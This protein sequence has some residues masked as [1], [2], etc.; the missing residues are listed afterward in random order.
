ML[1]IHL[2]LHTKW[3]WILETLSIQQTYFIYAARITT[4][5]TVRIQKYK[6]RYALPKFIWYPWQMKQKVKSKN[7]NG[8]F[9]FNTAFN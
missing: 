5:R 1:V 7:R 9:H 3:L 8:L 4:V 2:I 6:Y